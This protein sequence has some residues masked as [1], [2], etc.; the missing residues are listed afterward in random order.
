MRI[1]ILVTW[2]A[3]AESL[4]VSDTQKTK[5][6]RHLISHNI[7]HII[8]VPFLFIHSFSYPF[9]FFFLS[10]SCFLFCC[11]FF[12]HSHSLFFHIHLLHSWLFL[13][14]LY[15]THCDAHIIAYCMP[16]YFFQIKLFIDSSLPFLCLALPFLSYHIPSLTFTFTSP[17]KSHKTF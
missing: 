11:L 17:I 14:I 9:L 12:F 5:H 1:P 4:H 13:T 15:L 16:T 7:S 6:Q 3:P 10:L 8:S 2:I